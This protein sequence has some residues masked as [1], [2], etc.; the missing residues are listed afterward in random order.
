VTLI[1][2][3]EFSVADYQ[4]VGRNWKFNDGPDDCES[5]D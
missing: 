2:L 3:G 1:G 5:E 4:V